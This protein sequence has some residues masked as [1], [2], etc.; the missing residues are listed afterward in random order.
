MSLTQ[1]VPWASLTL[2]SNCCLDNPRRPWRPWREGMAS[3]PG[4]AGRKPHVGSTLSP[5]R[6]HLV[7]PTGFPCAL[8]S[9]EPLHPP[10]QV[11]DQRINSQECKKE[12][13]R[14]VL[15]MS[16]WSFEFF[17]GP[18]CDFGVRVE[19]SYHQKETFRNSR[20]QCCD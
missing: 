2:R 20:T 3:G 16:Q 1:T 13:K 11:I 15:S 4:R 19:R 14:A 5:T 7:V 10:K 12:N 18:T 17:S 8:R 9:R 6:H